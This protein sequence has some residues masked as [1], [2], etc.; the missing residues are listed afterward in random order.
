MQHAIHIACLGNGELC[1]ESIVSQLNLSR[2][3]LQSP[4]ILMVVARDDFRS[5]K[6]EVVA[7]SRIPMSLSGLKYESLCQLKEHVAMKRALRGFIG[8]TSGIDQRFLWKPIRPGI[9]ADVERSQIPLTAR[10]PELDR[11]ST[12]AFLSPRRCPEVQG[13][14]KQPPR[15]SIVAKEPSKRKE[16]PA[17][18]MRTEERTTFDE[19]TPNRLVQKWISAPDE[20]EQLDVIPK[21]FRLMKSKGIFV[22]I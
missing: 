11:T 18:S 9:S 12:F 22:H 14:V 16:G 15:R 13:V 1:T 6:K 17:T 7:G 2:P 10:L 19:A 8:N 20:I 5:G 4:S 21:E 3:N